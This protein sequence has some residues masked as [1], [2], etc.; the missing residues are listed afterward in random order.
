MS[1][2]SESV[3]LAGSGLVF[4]NSYSAAVT[5][6]FRASII[7]AENTL[8]S[9]FINPLTVSVSFD[10]A[11]L[12][13]RFI[14]QNTFD[15]INVSYETL[16][17]ALRA[18]ATSENDV[19][20]VNGLPPSDPSN[21]VGFSI[22]I[23]QA[24]LLGL[25]SPTSAII[26]TIILNSGLNLTFGQDVVGAIEHELSE[27]VFGRIASLGV[28]QPQW[29]TL[30]LFRFASTGQRDFTGGSDGVTTFFGLDANHVS[31]LDFHN[32]VSPTGTIDPFDL[33]DWES[34]VGDAFGPASGGTPAGLSP[35]DLQVLDVLG[36]TPKIASTAG[37]GLTGQ[38][39][40]GGG[41]DNTLIGGAGNDTITGGP[42]ANYLRGGPGNDVI[43]GGPG[44]NDMNGNQGNDTIHGGSGDNWVVGGQGN[45]LLFGGG[46]TN[47]IL[48]NLGDDT[49]HAGSGDDVLRGGQGDDVIFGGQGAD[50]ISG[51]L[52]H[53]TETGGAGPDTFH[54]FAAVGLDLVTNFSQAKGDHVQLDPGT[55]YAVSQVGADTVINMVGGGEVV[56]QGVLMTSLH[57][58][59]IVVG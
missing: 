39:L 44:F 33:G 15:Q 12:G 55:A 40:I 4:I 54:S 34:T 58:G 57:P 22:P 37:Q 1:M 25:V 45:D 36:W 5:D 14:A 21:G 28:I 19:L 32:S 11:A 48:G 16:T 23:A 18:H 10:Y 35:T 31:T 7:D 30:D 42:H 49:L 41:G 43:N 9:N 46:G 59:W 38:V 20:A 50:F 6:A 26:D 24:V 47:L 53:N 2:A 52:G 56:L 8:Q 17:A 27:G 51:D 3:S 13:K 29:H